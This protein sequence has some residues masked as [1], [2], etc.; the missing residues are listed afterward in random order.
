M[1][2]K[3]GVLIVHCVYFYFSFRFFLVRLDVLGLFWSTDE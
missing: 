2:K 3:R 1:E